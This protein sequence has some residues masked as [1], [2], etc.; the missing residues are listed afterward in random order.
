MANQ[1]H[2]LACSDSDTKCPK[3]QDL[4]SDKLSATNPEIKTM[5]QVLKRDPMRVYDKY[6]TN[7]KTRH[8]YIGSFRRFLGYLH[9]TD[10]NYLLELP[11]K[12]LFEIMENY[13][14]HLRTRVENGDLR[15][16]SIRIELAGI[17][18]F[19]TYNSD[20]DVNIGIITALFWL[21]ISFL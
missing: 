6:V 20:D 14:L 9:I 2:L 16:T 18:H 13:T 19:F 8:Q 3:N 17:A 10:P 12:E 21:G 1:R 11:K 7:L 15:V 5:S 4:G